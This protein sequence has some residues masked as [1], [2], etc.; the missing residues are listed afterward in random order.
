MRCHHPIKLN[1]N[2]NTIHHLSLF[3]IDFNVHIIVIIFIHLVYIDVLGIIF[4]PI[5][6]I[7]TSV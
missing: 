1:T 5:I 6:F 7:C 4:I 2:I 3:N